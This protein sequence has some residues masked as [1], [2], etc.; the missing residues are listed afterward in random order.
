MS[1]HNDLSAAMQHLITSQQLGEFNGL[2]QNQYRWRVAMARICQ[3]QRDLEG[4]L[5]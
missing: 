2:P 5:E 4:A 1:E 3:A